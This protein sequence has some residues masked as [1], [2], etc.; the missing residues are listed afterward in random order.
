MTALIKLSPLFFVSLPSLA[1][2]SAQVAEQTVVIQEQVEQAEKMEQELAE[3]L[4]I[5]EEKKAAEAA[6]EAKKAAEVVTPDPPA[7]LPVPAE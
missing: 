4:R 5:L 3:I 2:D 7:D 6:A 1:D